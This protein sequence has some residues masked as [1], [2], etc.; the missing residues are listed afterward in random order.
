MLAIV[1][2][3]LFFVTFFAPSSK[4]Y[5]SLVPGRCFRTRTVHYQHQQHC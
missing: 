5:L 3:G 2:L 4:E 1:L